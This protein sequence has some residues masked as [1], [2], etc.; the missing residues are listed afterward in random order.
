MTAFAAAAPSAPSNN[1]SSAAACQASSVIS[2]KPLRP[3]SQWLCLPCA[4]DREAPVMLVQWILVVVQ[5]QVG[6]GT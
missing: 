1:I 3:A 6:A 4:A 2:Q 5:A